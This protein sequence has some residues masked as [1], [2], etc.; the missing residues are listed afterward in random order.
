[1]FLGSKCTISIFVI[2]SLNQG[3]INVFI[4]FLAFASPPRKLLLQEI[5]KAEEFQV[6]I[7]R[8]NGKRMIKYYYLI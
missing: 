1:M 3:I 2:S 5:T 4:L 8:L 6:Q 7:T